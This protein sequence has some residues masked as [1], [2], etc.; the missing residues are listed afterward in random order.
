M[1]G[2]GGSNGVVVSGSCRWMFYA[3]QH[4]LE[5]VR[6]LVKLEPTR[7]DDGQPTQSIQST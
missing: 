5:E 7:G 3:L 6:V 1:A 2:S 4:F